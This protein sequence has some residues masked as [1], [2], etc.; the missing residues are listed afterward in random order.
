MKEMIDFFTANANGCLATVSDGKPRVRP[1]MFAMEHDNKCYFST[2]NKKDVFRQL[3]NV[4]YAAFTST[5]PDMVTARVQ[6]VIEFSN[7]FELKKKI[8]D[9]HDLV[10][11]I[12][13][14][15]DNPALEL[16][17]IAAGEATLSDFSGNPP[18]A[19]KF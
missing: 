19:F 16:F 9:M 1:F 3:K 11:S 7:D 17:Y 18:K 8:F 2:S 10:R 14:T 4:P 13:K 6:G 12:Y 5:S 15:P